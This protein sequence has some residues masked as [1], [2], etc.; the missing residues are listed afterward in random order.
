MP[1]EHGHISIEKQGTFEGKRTTKNESRFSSV[2][3]RGSGQAFITLRT[4]FWI[5]P[6][7]LLEALRLPNQMTRQ[8]GLIQCSSNLGKPQGKT[9]DSRAHGLAFHS[10]QKLVKPRKGK[11]RETESDKES[12]ASAFP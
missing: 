1:C 12:K 2:S 8:S 6:L 5:Q 7:K 10:R 11:K 9:Q 4:V 3:T